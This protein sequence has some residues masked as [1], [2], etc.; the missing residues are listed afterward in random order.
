MDV[1]S[2]PDF[3]TFVIVTLFLT[4]LLPTSFLMPV[5]KHFIILY[6][7]TSK[8]GESHLTPDPFSNY[9]VDTHSIHSPLSESF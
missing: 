7:L 5:L 9:I 2:T 6:N 1:L 8:L 4:H 3:N